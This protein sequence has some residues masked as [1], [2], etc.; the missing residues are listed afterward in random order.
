MAQGY[1]DTLCS[2]SMLRTDHPHVPTERRRRPHIDAFAE[3][4]LTDGSHLIPRSSLLDA[5]EDDDDID[6]PKDPF[7][8]PVSQSPK[9]LDELLAML[10]FKD[11]RMH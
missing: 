4:P 6:W 10:H 8:R 1:D 5:V 9:S 7:D 3:H 11:S 2:L